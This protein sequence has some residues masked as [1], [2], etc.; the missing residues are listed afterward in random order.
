MKVIIPVVENK[1]TSHLIVDEFRNA[2]M[3]CV[4]DRATQSND[5][6]PIEQIIKS[7]GNLTLELRSKGIDTVISTNMS[8]LSLSLLLDSEF[9]VYQARGNDPESNIQLFLQNQLE[10]FNRLHALRSFGCSPNACG[11]CLDCN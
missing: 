9:K 4:F 10:P 5:V 11:S 2:N 7:A 6:V 1:E 8:F 3:A